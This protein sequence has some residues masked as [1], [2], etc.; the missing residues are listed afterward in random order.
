V[1]VVR[2]VHLTDCILHA[3][4]LANLIEQCQSRKFLFLKDL[5][6]DEDQCRVLGVYSRPDLEI[7]LDDCTISDAGASTL[8]EVLGRNQGPTKL[9]DCDID[10]FVLAN[11]LRGNSRRA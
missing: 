7:V 1:S 3:T 5:E 4:T 2:S 10:N 11:G 8:A 6:I 9:N